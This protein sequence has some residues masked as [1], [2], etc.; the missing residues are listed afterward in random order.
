VARAGGK[1]EGFTLDGNENYHAVQPF[2]DLWETL[3]SD[4][5]LSPFMSKLQ[6]VEQPLHRDVSLSQEARDAFV[7]WDKRP[8]M[9][10]DESDASVESLPQALRCGYVG[11]SYKN[12]KGVFKG[13]ANACLVRWLNKRDP[14]RPYVI[15]AEDLSNVAPVALPQD[16][17]SLSS[18]GIANPERNGHHYFRGLSMFPD[19]VQRSVVGAH[20]DLYQ[21]HRDGFA[22]LQVRDGMLVVESVTSAPYGRGSDFDPSEFT[23]AKDWRFSSLGL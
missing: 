5:A 22:T 21:W 17:A 11:T 3:V 23:P 12:C 4:K 15:S 20:A 13:I 14:V 8:A 19:P 18:L 16:L 10:I 2:R 1:I 6:F 9:I 7:Q